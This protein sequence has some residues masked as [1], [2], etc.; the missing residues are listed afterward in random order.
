MNHDTICIAVW[1]SFFVRPTWQQPGGRSMHKERG[2][3]VMGEM[4]LSWQEYERRRRRLNSRLGIYILAM[5][6][7]PLVLLAKG[8]SPL[9]MLLTV[10]CGAVWIGVVYPLLWRARHNPDR[11]QSQE[12]WVVRVVATCRSI[13]VFSGVAAAVAWATLEEQSMRTARLVCVF[14][15]SILALACFLF[16]LHAQFK[17]G[18]RLWRPDA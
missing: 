16:S 15:F 5:I 14:A 8:V 7:V 3:T 17:S 13:A 10:I 18:R 1:V 6:P 2:D 9:W 12:K 4:E 11:H